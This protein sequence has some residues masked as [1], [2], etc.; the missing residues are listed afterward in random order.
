MSDNHSK[1]TVPIR[2]MWIPWAGY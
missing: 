1:Q 2:D